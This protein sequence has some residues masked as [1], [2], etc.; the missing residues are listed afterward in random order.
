MNHHRL[1]CYQRLLGVAKQMPT[2]MDRLHGHGYLADQLRRALSSGIL[3][4]S[5]GNGRQ[6]FKEKRRF[7]DISLAS[8]S[9][10]DAIFDLIGAYQLISGQQLAHLQ[11]EIR[12]SCAMIHV[13]RS[14]FQ[15][16]F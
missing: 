15:V 1:Q 3:N 11:S 14:R 7:F 2:L 6:S 13:L 12:G 8:L 16:Q 9:E 10:V 5:E 4:L